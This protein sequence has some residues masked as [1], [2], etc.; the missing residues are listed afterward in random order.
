MKIVKEYNIAIVGS[1]VYG[2]YTAKL[3]SLH[4]NLQISIFEVG[5]ERIK[6]D[7]DYGFSSNNLN[8]DYSGANKGRFFGLGGTSS[9]WGG[10]IL[11]FDKLS[12]KS[13][14]IFLNQLVNLNTK[15]SETV[16]KRIGLHAIRDSHKK[17][18]NSNFRI[19]K[20]DWLF[21]FRKNLFKIFNIKNLKKCNVITNSKVI[22]LENEKDYTKVFY[23]KNKQLLNKNFDYVFLCAGAFESAR[24]LVQ[25]NFENPK[26]NFSDHIGLKFAKSY[27]PLELLGLD[28]T[29]K[30]SRFSLS[31]LRISG[32]K[33]DRSFYIHPIYDMDQG[34]LKIIKKIIKNQFKLRDAFESLIL[35]ITDLFWIIKCLFYKRLMPPKNKWE[36]N[37]TIENINKNNFV[38]FFDN[39]K[40]TN[41]DMR[42]NYSVGNDLDKDINEIIDDYKI[43]L[44]DDKINFFKSSEFTNYED[45]YHPFGLL[46]F[47][48]LNHYKCKYK[49]ISCISTA[50]LPRSGSINPTGAIFPLIE[51]LVNEK[52]WIK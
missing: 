26:L 16:K 52:I 23:E 43:I 29:Y 11:F 51:H 32:E 42:I 1:G 10:K 39:K 9:K 17:N 28:F 38:E 44:N 40:Y 19:E 8:E 50:I 45:V 49:N 13:K 25:S 35:V 21:P 36:L 3:L 18:S 22:K 48:D 2:S 41:L 12:F 14:N 37:L 5:N 31:T 34:F 27:G 7:F 30:F 20:G 4:D 6:K 24:I 47:D 46:E 15:F 33:N